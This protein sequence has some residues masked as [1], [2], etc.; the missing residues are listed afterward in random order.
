MTK[1]KNLAC[2][3]ESCGS[4]FDKFVGEKLRA[5]RDLRHLTRSDLSE[6]LSVSS[7]LI[8]QYENGSVRMPLSTVFILSNALNVSVGYFLD[9]AKE[10]I[11]KTKTANDAYVSLDTRRHLNILIIESNAAGQLMLIKAIEAIKTIKTAL[12]AVHNAEA[13][14]NFLK[15]PNTPKPNLI[16]LNLNLPKLDGF[17]F[18]KTLNNHS[19][20][21][22]IPII[23]LTNSIKYSD[24]ERCYQHGIA[25]YFIKDLDFSRLK[26]YI[27]A[28]LHYWSL[29][30]TAI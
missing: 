7:S 15:K 12:Y 23:V 25:G 14:I 13:A 9:G 27:E 8:Q 1:S 6:I 3:F 2:D 11:A 19:K 16:L 20:F 30:Y 22:A 17:D 29:N 10:V 4:D 5:I 18:I 28:S 26:T 21:K 24:L